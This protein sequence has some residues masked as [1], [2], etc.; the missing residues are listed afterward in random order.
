MLPETP[1]FRAL[2]SYKWKS[3]NSCFIDAGLELLFRSFMKFPSHE[4][5]TLLVKQSVDDVHPRSC[6]T[7]SGRILGHLAQRRNWVNTTENVRKKGVVDRRGQEILQRGTEIV[8]EIL[9]E[10]WRDCIGGDPATE[11]GSPLTWVP[12]FGKVFI[13]MTRS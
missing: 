10:E 8:R 9:R 3:P 2:V 5:K 11:Y 4:W 7:P 6:P 1:G 13:S 12:Q